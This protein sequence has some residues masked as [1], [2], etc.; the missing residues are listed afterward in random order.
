MLLFLMEYNPQMLL[1][2]QFAV[3]SWLKLIIFLFISFYLTEKTG[4]NQE[5][6]I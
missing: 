3:Q 1:N 6:N 5:N 2:Y 4:N